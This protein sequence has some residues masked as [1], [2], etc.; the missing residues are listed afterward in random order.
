MARARK[1]PLRII[2]NQAT[3]M[4]ALGAQGILLQLRRA[5]HDALEQEVRLALIAEDKI[6][7]PIGVLLQPDRCHHWR[8]AFV[9]NWIECIR[10]RACSGG[11]AARDGGGGPY[12]RDCRSPRACH[13][14]AC[15]A[16]L[17]DES[18]CENQDGAEPHF[19]GNRTFMEKRAASISVLQGSVFQAAGGIALGAATG[20]CGD[21]T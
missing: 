7:P 18:G 14:A 11:G 19:R 3:E 9:Q 12:G 1:T 17:D 4:C 15:C 16:H 6:G 13:V 21:P 2:R 20:R 8:A 10:R 5:I